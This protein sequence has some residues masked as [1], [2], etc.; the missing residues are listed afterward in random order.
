MF[1]SDVLFNMYSSKQNLPN[2]EIDQMI[3]NLSFENDLID[4]TE[5]TN[6]RSALESFSGYIY[7]CH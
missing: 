3:S 2:Y 4:T 7:R 5:L 6:L 1:L